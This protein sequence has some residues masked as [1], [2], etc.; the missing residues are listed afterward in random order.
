MS[1][2]I[3]RGIKIEVDSEYLPERSDPQ[4]QFYFFAYH[5]TITNE[6]HETA[7]LISR[8]WIITDGEGKTE[9]VKGPGVIG[10]QPTLE[11]GDS[12]KYSSACP[13]KTPQGD[14]RGTYQMVTESGEKFD[15]QIAKFELAPTYTLH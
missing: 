7:Q 10:E 11:P 12:F 4:S 14:M 13:L 1:S 6:G 15:A 3:T 5:V 8:H 9:E 2:A